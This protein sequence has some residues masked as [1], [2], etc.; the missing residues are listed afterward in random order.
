VI[1]AAPAPQP[2]TPAPVVVQVPQEPDELVMTS[3]MLT[4]IYLRNPKP[5]YPNLSRR[6]SEQGTVLLRVFVT[7][8]GDASK[9][10][11]KES[12]GFPRLDHAALDAVQSWKFVPAKRGEQPVAAWVVV[13]IKFSL[14]G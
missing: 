13:P 8:A 12:S 4:A 7:M 10:E 1:V 5:A 11:L 3:Q 9:I 6:L 2:I 14:K